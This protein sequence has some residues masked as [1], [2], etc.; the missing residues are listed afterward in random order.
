MRVSYGPL[1]RALAF[2]REASE[3]S[4]SILDWAYKDS[5]LG[6]RTRASQDLLSKS[7]IP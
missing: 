4:V 2:F 1:V 6:A 3:V 7:G 5:E